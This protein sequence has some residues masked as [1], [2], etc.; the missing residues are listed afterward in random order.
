MKDVTVGQKLVQTLF[1]VLQQ[2][3]ASDVCDRSLPF[4]GKR[5][6]FTAPRDE[7]DSE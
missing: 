3:A 7:S 6:F 4:R 1:S 5:D 2:D